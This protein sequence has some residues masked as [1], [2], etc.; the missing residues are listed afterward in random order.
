MADEVDHPPFRQ[1]RR[2]DGAIGTETPTLTDLCTAASRH[3]EEAER[4]RWQAESLTA[5]LDERDPQAKT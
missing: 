1:K 2:D 3:A 5:Y 4:I